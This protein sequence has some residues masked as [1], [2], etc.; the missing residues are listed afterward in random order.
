MK[1]KNQIALT[2][3]TVGFI[4]ISVISM[5]ISAERFPAMHFWPSRPTFEAISAITSLGL[6]LPLFFMASFS[7]GYLVA[8][9]LFSMTLGFI[10]LSFFSEFAYSHDLARWIIATAFLSAIIPLLFINRLK[11]PL[12]TAPV[13]PNLNSF[14]LIVCL[15]ILI[16]DASYGLQLG[17]P[18]G[19]LRN[20]VT[21]P[22][23]LNYLTSIA[24]GTA[25]PF[26]F[27]S[28]ATERK[29]WPAAG[30]LLLALCFYPVVLNKTVLLLPLWLPFIFLLYSRCDGRIATILSLLIPLGF[31][32]TAS[33]FLI[34]R[35]SELQIY[36]LGTVNLRL[37]AVPSLAL[38]QYID[39]FSQ[40]PKTKF[41][42][43]SIVRY[44]FGCLYSELGPMIGEVYKDG[45]FNAS[46]LAS[47]GIASVGLLWTPI[48]AFFCGV[49]LSI[50]TLVSRHLDSRFVAV[51]SSLA[52]QAIMNVPLT[53]A[54]L[55]NGL[56]LLFLLWWLTPN[57]DVA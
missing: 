32:T 52:I 43:I 41:C 3:L 11:T 25:I 35:S 40:N 8:F 1:F 34:P 21:R 23:L 14:I 7:F 10:W 29:W 18:Y 42:Q 44:F 5:M 2:V 16:L 47:E 17:D 36:L 24:I 30:V 22:R 53:T 13:I 37:I 48:S 57:R 4:V 33:L 6:V 51:S 45:N 46:F 28:Y 19:A 9:F 55:S 12:P 39:F 26:L 31:T 50:G 27:A 20:A 49:V 56:A 54:F 38:D 15:G